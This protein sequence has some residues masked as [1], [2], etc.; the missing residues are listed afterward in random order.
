L[1]RRPGIGNASFG[2]QN[3][4]AQVEGDAIKCGEQAMSPSQFANLR[5]SGNRNAW[6]AVWLHLPG[7]EEWLLADVCRSARAARAQ[8]ATRRPARSQPPGTEPTR[9]WPAPPS[10]RDA[11]KRAWSNAIMCAS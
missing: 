11:A 7:S 10:T 5:G 8:A 6:K 3:Y 4:F 1:R 9:R 2:G